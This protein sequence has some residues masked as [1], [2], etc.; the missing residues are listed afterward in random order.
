MTSNRSYRNAIPQHIVREE[1]VKG[2]GIQF[3]PEYARIMI[4][5]FR[6]SNLKRRSG[7][8]PE[9]DP[10]RG[11]SPGSDYILISLSATFSA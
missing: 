8:D 3:D 5:F 4:I 2:S 1:L 9:L 10:F 7:V 6:L 11:I